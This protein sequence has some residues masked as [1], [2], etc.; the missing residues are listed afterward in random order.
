MCDCHDES[1]ANVIALGFGLAIWQCHG[2][3]ICRISLYCRRMPSF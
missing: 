2:R 3:V 1:T